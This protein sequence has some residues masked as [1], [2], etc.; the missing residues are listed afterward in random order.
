M[1][2]YNNIFSILFRK[3]CDTYY[4]HNKYTVFHFTAH[5]FKY[6][7]KSVIYNK[8]LNN[9]IISKN[10]KTEFIKLY[11]EACRLLRIFQFFYS[12]AIYKKTDSYH[13]VVDMNFD[14]LYTIKP[15]FLF[16]FCQ[17][18]KLYTFSVSDM[19]RIINNSLIS[20]DSD[21]LS[22]CKFPKNP[23]NNINIPKVI[24]YKLY[25][26][27]KS[28]DKMP[29]IFKKFVDCSFS[30]KTF[31]G[32]NEVFIRDYTID[33]YNKILTTD[34]IY[35]QTILFLRFKNIPNLFIHIDFPKEQVIKKFELAVTY[36]RHMCYSLSSL[37]KEYYYT[38]FNKNIA[39][40]MTNEPTFGRIILKRKFKKKLYPHINYTIVNVMDNR[41]PNFDTLQ[42]L[43]EFMEFGLIIPT[44]VTDDSEA[45]MDDE[46]EIMVDSENNAESDGGPE[47]NNI[48][49]ISFDMVSDYL[50]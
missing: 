26:Q 14:P 43:Y 2:F 19:V 30:V 5:D 50:Y 36:F 1:F 7:N 47:Y 37:A 38:L 22:Y 34:Q 46:S 44:V 24:L 33:N 3:V 25:L 9:F 49:N 11:I 39:K 27:L 23:Y 29:E 15:Q 4:P 13:S 45:Y 12:K 48:N 35:E 20:F 17:N 42:S 16:K 28:Y 21:L 10:D 40:I 18:N 8:F 31:V 41:I 6:E 32:K